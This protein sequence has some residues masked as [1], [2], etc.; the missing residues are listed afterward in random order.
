MP[1][2]G[3]NLDQLPI[4]MLVIA[5]SGFGK[6]GS[7]ASLAAAGFKLHIADYDNGT[8]I[9]L[10]YL[11]K[12]YWP[13]VE[14]ETFT[15]KFKILGDKA[16]PLSA[17]AWQQGLAKMNKWIDTFNAA[18][19]PT[20]HILVID[21]LTLLAQAAFRHILALN[22]RLGTRP[23]QA[24]WG[25]AQRLLEDLLAMLYAK[26]VKCHVIIMSH[27]TYFGGPDPY[28]DENEQKTAQDVKPIQGLP[29]TIG[30]ALSPNVPRYF[31]NML[32]GKVVGEGPNAQRLLYTVP[33][34]LVPAKA[35]A[36]LKS[37]Y[38]IATGLADIFKTLR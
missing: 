22:R 11:D 15:D 38:P 16:M 32:V 35:S 26:D 19:K 30:K 13:N 36:K 31:N 27:I 5:N 3:S 14:V 20:E 29:T 23:F 33:T 28:A 37:F 7:L 18:E 9:L 12:Q 2:L 1:V 8:E 25:E 10:G 24:D 4:K 6:T 17:A 21:S 34:D